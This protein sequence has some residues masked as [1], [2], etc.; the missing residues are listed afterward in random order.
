MWID[1]EKEQES[2]LAWLSDH[3][4]SLRN[5]PLQ[6]SLED[7]QKQLTHLKDVS[8]SISEKE[9]E[10]DLFMDKGHGLVQKCEVEP[11][12]SVVSQVSQRWA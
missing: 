10:I 1:F 9:K 7:K 11:L 12:K 2:T 3:E 8:R 4:M 6:S 5:Q